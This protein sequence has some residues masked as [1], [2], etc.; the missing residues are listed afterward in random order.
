MTS[1]YTGGTSNDLMTDYVGQQIRAIN[2]K[3]VVDFGAG[4]GKMGSICR[5]LMGDNAH[6]IAVEGCE[7]TAGDLSASGIYNRVDFDM[8]EDWVLDNTDRC[9]LA[10]FGDVLEHLTRRQAIA[11][12]N[13]T[14][15]FASNVVINIPLRNLRQDGAE[16]NVLEEHHGY[17]TERSFDRGFFVREKH[18]T[19]P[20][21]GYSKMNVWITG[22]R[23][24]RLKNA[25][26][27]MLL[28]HFGRPARV[29]LEKLGYDGYV[30][31]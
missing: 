10:I 25:I 18:V 21:A 29:A 23:R 31:G 8:I 2:P 20:S 27:G 11:V 30:A 7:A 6:L 16:T 17:F 1:T 4:L 5:Q 26:K 13:Q 19:S 28:Y 14:L 3:R 15:T 12:L 9:D 24:F 22:R